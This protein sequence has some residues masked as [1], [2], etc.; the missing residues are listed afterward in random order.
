VRNVTPNLP[1]FAAAFVCSGRRTT[2]ITILT[3]P[4][5][6]LSTIFGMNVDLPYGAGPTLF[7]TVNAIGVLLTVAV[8]YYLR[9]RRWL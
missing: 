7:Y 5:T 6:V 3:V 1:Q 4:L 9:R 2:V 8:I